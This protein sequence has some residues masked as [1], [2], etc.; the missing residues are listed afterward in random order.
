MFVPWWM[1]Q[2][3]VQSC[4]SIRSIESVCYTLQLFSVRASRQW[5]LFQEM[6][7]AT[8]ALFLFCTC[9]PV[10]LPKTCYLQT[11]QVRDT[12]LWL[13]QRK[14][15]D[16]PNACC[17]RTT[18]VMPCA[19]RLCFLEASWYTFWLS[20]RLQVWDL[21]GPNAFWYLKGKQVPLVL[22]DSHDLWNSSGRLQQSTVWKAQEAH[23]PLSRTVMSNVDQK[24]ST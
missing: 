2:I 17:W 4:G 16:S 10:R 18:W 19:N 12:F 15:P 9:Q 3:V 21:Q 7:L 11:Q 8:V 22:T 20:Q 1:L 14:R 23:E 6:S 13:N 5:H 24:S